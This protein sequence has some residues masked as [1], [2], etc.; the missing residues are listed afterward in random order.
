MPPSMTVGP[1]ECAAMEPPVTIPKGQHAARS[2]GDAFRAITA[3]PQATLL[4]AAVIALPLLL[5]T[6]IGAASPQLWVS[7]AVPALAGLT[8]AIWLPV[9]AIR[10]NEAISHGSEATFG[11]IL[12]A[13]TNMRI[14]SFMGT[15]IVVGLLRMLVIVIAF[16][17]F[18]GTMVA[19][20]AGAQ[21]DF[22][23][24]LGGPQAALLGLS[25]L[26][27]LGLGLVGTLVISLRYGLSGVVNVIERTGPIR[28]LGRSRE[29]LKG[30]GF[31]YFLLLLLL[32]A[33][34]LVAG[35][36]LGGPRLIVAA[37]NDLTKAA[38]GLPPAAAMV[39]GVSA[40][41]STI[42]TVLVSW[43]SRTN[44]YLHCMV[45][46]PPASDQLLVAPD[47]DQDPGKEQETSGHDENPWKLPE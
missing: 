1:L 5:G 31:D 43:G 24:A 30:R 18:V 6:T 3:Y 15:Q 42:V 28:S 34:T 22:E 20:L 37:S 36:V 7:F 19:A 21:G 4:V 27:G 32:L 35:L 26:V 2:M 11:S 38:V 16:A 45:E 44:Y 8:A 33:V 17:P 46:D 41:L 14:F 12:G 25:L 10:A 29:L 9:A 40:Y 39:I 47:G 13:A 23:R